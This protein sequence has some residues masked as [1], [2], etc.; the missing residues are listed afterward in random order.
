LDFAK[1]VTAILCICSFA[2]QFAVIVSQ[3]MVE[4][5]LGISHYVDLSSVASSFHTVNAINSVMLTILLGV[6]IAPVFQIPKDWTG[7]IVI[8]LA[9]MVEVAFVLEM[10]FPQLSSF[11]ESWMLLTRIGLRYI[12]DS[13]FRLLSNLGVE[14]VVI[15][16]LFVFVTYLF[17]GLTVGTFL[18]ESRATRKSISMHMKSFLVGGENEDVEPYPDVKPLSQQSLMSTEEP[19]ADPQIESELMTSVEILAGRALS[20]IHGMKNRMEQELETARNVLI[21][22]SGRVRDI[23]HRLG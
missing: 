23:Q 10:R 1:I 16:V 7:T 2:I 5:N 22:A 13:D 11:P 12:R 8:F 17:L 19:H 6:I 15:L 3:P 9:V 21:E 18:A 4:A 20:E 14:I